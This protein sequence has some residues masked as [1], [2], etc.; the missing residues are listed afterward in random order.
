MLTE[1]GPVPC[2]AGTVLT[3]HAGHPLA[4][5]LKTLQLGELMQ[6]KL[7]YIPPMRADR[8][9]GCPHCGALMMDSDGR[10]YVARAD[11]PTIAPAE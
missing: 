8:V 9:G 10:Y 6:G 3:C 5:T 4:K 11:T 1:P 7:E 2:P